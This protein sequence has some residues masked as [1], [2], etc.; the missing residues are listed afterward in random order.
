[1]WPRSLK[2]SILGAGDF[3]GQ[4]PIPVHLKNTV[5][6]PTGY[7]ERWNPVRVDN[8]DSHPWVL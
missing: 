5:S 7:V 2:A 1:M 6:H 8:P 3:E 4:V